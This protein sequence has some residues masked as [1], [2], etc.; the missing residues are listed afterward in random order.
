VNGAQKTVRVKLDAGR[1]VNTEYS[2]EINFKKITENIEDSNHKANLN[3]NKF[4]S[5]KV[6]P[7]A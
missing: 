7:L 6:A 4:T 2:K 3:L 1:R 5:T